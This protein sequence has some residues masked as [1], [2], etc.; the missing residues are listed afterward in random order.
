MNVFLHFDYFFL[1]FSDGKCVM[2]AIAAAKLHLFL[3]T[4]HTH[5]QF[6]LF[7]IKK[8]I[9]DTGNHGKK[10]LHFPDRGPVSAFTNGTSACRNG[11]SKFRSAASVCLFLRPDEN[12]R[13]TK[14]SKT[15]QKFLTLSP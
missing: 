4:E 12:Q 1:L 14:P 9:P 7:T 11:V 6:F 10:S 8:C 13:I 15:F 5:W 2:V 3:I